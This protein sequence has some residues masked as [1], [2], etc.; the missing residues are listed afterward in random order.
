MLAEQGTIRRDPVDHQV[1]KQAQAVLTRGAGEAAQR[2]RGALLRLEYGMQT[3][4]IA[5]NLR[6]PSPS[7]LEQRADQDV[8]EA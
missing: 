5:D 2:L 6:V 8:I 3:T 4:V 7:G 1:G